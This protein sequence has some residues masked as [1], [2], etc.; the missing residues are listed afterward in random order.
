MHYLR[1]KGKEYYIYKIADE[2][3]YI[4]VNELFYTILKSRAM[5]TRSIHYIHVYTDYR[6]LS[7][8]F[9]FPFKT[10]SII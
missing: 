1:G 3:I 5:R 4:I 9:C 6:K 10:L 7:F 2:Y 8:D